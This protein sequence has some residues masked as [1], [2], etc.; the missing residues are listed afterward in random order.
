MISIPKILPAAHIFV[1]VEWQSKKRAFEQVSIVFENTS[2]I[3]R[4]TIF[5]ALIE[6]E[7]LG[8]TFIGNG[9]AIPHGRLEQLPAPLCALALLKKTIRYSVDGVDG[10][11]RTLFFMIAPPDTQDTHLW[12]LG[13]FSEMLTDVAL[14]DKLHNG[15]DPEQAVAL[16][17]QWKSAL[18]EAGRQ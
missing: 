9:G 7:R 8:S 14:I 6:R 11:V 16:L 13:M 5:S 17:A 3:P 2:G 15:A 12:L 10:D 1:N 4:D 18:P